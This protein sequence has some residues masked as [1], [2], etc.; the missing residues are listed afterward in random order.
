[1]SHDNIKFSVT[2]A[3]NLG[4]P[5]YGGEH[6]CEKIAAKPGEWLAWVDTVESFGHRISKL[7]ARCLGPR[8]I[9]HNNSKHSYKTYNLGVDA[10]LMSIQPIEHLISEIEYANALNEAY[11][12]DS[13]FDFALVRNG[14]WSSTG[15]GDGCYE[16]VVHY[17][18]GKAVEIDIVFIDDDDV[19]EDFYV[20]ED[21]VDYYDDIAEDYEEEHFE[22]DTDG[23]D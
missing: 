17:I 2:D 4:D 23:D 3:L 10:G 6:G 20:E 18:D 5:C 1:M 12:K 15:Y 8:Q 9:E 11:G 16:A 21:D 13:N 19:E 22:A 14:V 7:H